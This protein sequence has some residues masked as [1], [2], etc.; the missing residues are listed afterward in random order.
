MK[1]TT[2]QTTFYVLRQVSAPRHNLGIFTNTTDML[3]KATDYFK[4]NLKDNNLVHLRYDQFNI[5]N[6]I[7]SLK[8]HNHIVCY[9]HVIEHATLAYSDNCY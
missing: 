9:D 3:S 6:D 2:N 1:K 4:E 5:T 8:G 7:Q